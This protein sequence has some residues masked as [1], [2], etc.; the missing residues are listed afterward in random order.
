[1]SGIDSFYSGIGQS[2]YAGSS[3]EYVSGSQTVGSAIT[4]NG[5][6]VDTSTATGGSQ[7]GP[8]LTEVC[9]VLSLN[10]IKPATNS[11]Y[12]VY[13]DLKRGN[14]G[15]C[16][17]HSYGTCGGV[18]VEFAF[19]FNL[20]GDA[21]CDPQDNLSGH[22][23]N[24]AALANVSGHELSEARTDP[25]LNAWYDNSGSENADKCAWTF[26]NTLLPFNNGTYWKVQGN[27]S[28]NAYNSGTGY[29]QGCIDG[30]L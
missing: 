28:N 22:S 25:S 11:Y 23:Q 26:G 9:K 13:V 24:L 7:T 29:S 19:F 10:G 14:A 2:N 30:G 20:D 4:Y 3:D 27:W 18:I 5:H 17:W 1:M 8:I 21:G 16:A 6:F 12:P 15:Y